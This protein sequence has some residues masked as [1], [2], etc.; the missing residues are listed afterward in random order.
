MGFKTDFKPVH[1]TENYY[2]YRQYSPKK[3]EQ[4]RTIHMGKEKAIIGGKPNPF[5]NKET[6]QKEYDERMEKM[7]KEDHHMKGTLADIHKKMYKK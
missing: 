5:Y 6:Y 7:K 2:R 4:Y 1:E 3:D